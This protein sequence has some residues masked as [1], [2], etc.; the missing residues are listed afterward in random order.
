M[1]ELKTEGRVRF[2]GISNHGTFW[3]GDPEE[4][5]EKILLAAAED[6]R[7]DVMLFV[8]NFLAKENGEKV[9]KVCSKKNIG[10]TLMKTNPV[11]D[12]LYFQY[13]VEKYKKEGKEVPKFYSKLFD[14][15]E[16]LVEE[17]Q[18]F[19]KKHNLKN[20]DN[21]RDAAIRY[22]LNNPFVNSVCTTFVNFDDVEGYLKLSGS[23]FSL[24]DKRKLAAYREGCSVFYC[25]HACGMCEAS[26][27]HHVP[28][29]TVMRYNHYFVSQHREKHAMQ[30]Y[31]GLPTAKADRC[32]N[33]DGLCE[34]ACPFN[35]PIHALLIEAH[36]RLSFT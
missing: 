16:K 25:R 7:F 6:G 18:G 11:A 22:S 1:S 27:P 5:M 26:C 20:P 30:K 32:S 12:Y 35:V 24:Q 28:V 21:I 10:T 19:V 4:S 29:N 15:Y 17:S 23:R 31:S 14:R 13:E 33:C 2:L 34:A 8:Y 3:T 36:N 9:L